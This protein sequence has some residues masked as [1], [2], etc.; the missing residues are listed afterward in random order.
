MSVT[1]PPELL[2]I[3]SPDDEAEVIVCDADGAWVVD[4]SERAESHQSA[5]VGSSVNIGHN[6][7]VIRPL[8]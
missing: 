3:S 2:P 1:Y 5:S 6:S 4:S 7:S 8:H